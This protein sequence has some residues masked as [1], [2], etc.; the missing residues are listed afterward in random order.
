M[1]P[2]SLEQF[3][4]HLGFPW[5]FP[6]SHQAGQWVFGLWVWCPPM[7]HTLPL[8][9]SLF[10]CGA[11]N[12]TRSPAAGSGPW[13]ASRAGV[14]KDAVSARTRGPFPLRSTWRLLVKEEDVQRAQS[15]EQV[16]RGQ[17]KGAGGWQRVGAVHKTPWCTWSLL[18]GVLGCMVPLYP[19]WAQRMLWHGGLSIGTGKESAAGGELRPPHQRGDRGSGVI[20]SSSSVG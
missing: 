15:H 16:K 7:H 4:Q 3:S 20:S 12:P 19:A 8:S 2:L 14:Q 11:L 9:R 5:V 6:A 10:G 18:S 1:P 17:Q 13:S